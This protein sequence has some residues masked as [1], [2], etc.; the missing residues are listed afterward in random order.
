V[1]NPPPLNQAFPLVVG[2]IS[3]NR[4]VLN[5]FSKDILA[6]S[7]NVEEDLIE[8]V[9]SK[10]PDRLVKPTGQVKKLVESCLVLMAL[11]MLL[12]RSR[13]HNVVGFNVEEDL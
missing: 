13:C 12:R 6:E 8:E 3:G 10:P 1:I 11:A 9:Q 5:G 2:E 4:G 7:F